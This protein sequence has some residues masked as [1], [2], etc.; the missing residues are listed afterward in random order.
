KDADGGKDAAR[1]QPRIGL[2]I[3]GVSGSMAANVRAHVTLGSKVCT[4]A[5]GYVRALARRAQDEAAEALRA[6]G[7]YEASAS[8][9]V[10]REG[11]CPR[12]RVLV[13][14]GERVRVR[15][16]DLTI[17]GAAADDDA[18]M[19]AFDEPP[20]RAGQGLNHKR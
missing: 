13:T 14:P 1:E 16:V 17:S 7:Y 3:E 9:E 19:S 18:F 2:D 8:V 4:T 12:A 20:I 5:P 11:D 10:N 15:R 6:F